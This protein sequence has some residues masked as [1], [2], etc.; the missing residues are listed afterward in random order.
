MVWSEV[1]GLCGVWDGSCESGTYGAGIVTQVFE[2]PHARLYPIEIHWFLKRKYEFSSCD[3]RTRLHP[4]L[5]DV[6]LC[7]FGVRSLDLQNSVCLVSLS[8]SIFLCMSFF[9]FF[10]REKWMKVSA[11]NSRTVENH[12]YRSAPGTSHR[13]GTSPSA[14][15]GTRPRRDSAKELATT[16]P[17]IELHRRIQAATALPLRGG[18]TPRTLADTR[19]RRN[20]DVSEEKRPPTSAPTTTRR[21]FHHVRPILGISSLW[22]C[23][24]PPRQCRSCAQRDVWWSHQLWSET[25]ESC[26]QRVVHLA[27]GGGHQRWSQVFG[28]PS[29]WTHPNRGRG[30]SR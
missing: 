21:A 24:L 22:L 27:R 25:P 1:A 8:L 23:A 19:P 2:L 4:S 28:H 10:L 3:M 16:Q 20:W 30:P 12:A 7:R 14:P 26:R 13:E 11:H 15:G 9:F 18:G 17:N 29:G 6:S 5:Y